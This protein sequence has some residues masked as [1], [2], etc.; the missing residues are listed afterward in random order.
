M[1][2]A[3][4]EY[5]RALAEVSDCAGSP[6][7]LSS[8]VG[9]AVRIDN[10]RAAEELTW[11]RALVRHLPRT[12]AALRVGTIDLYK[13][14][15]VA[16]L[17]TSLSV[18][19]L[20]RAD[21]L[22]EK[23][24]KKTPKNLRRAV[25]GVVKNVDPDGDEERRKKCEAGR[26]VALSHRDHGW[27]VLSADLPCH[28]ASAIY[29]SLTDAAR[30]LRKIDPSRTMDQL[31]ADIFADRLLNAVNGTASV[32]AQVYVYVDLFTLWSLNNDPGYLPGYGEIPADLA[33]QIAADPNSIWTR[34]ITDPDTGQ[35]LSVGR[36]KY[37][38]PA[39]LADYVRIRARTCEHPGCNQPA[40]F[41]DIDHTEDW[42]LGGETNADTLGGRC[43]YHHLLK[44][45]PGWHY[46]ANPD[47]TTT[48]TTPAG[49]T[50][51]SKP[52]PIHKPRS[53]P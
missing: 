8:E 36:T 4:E 9:L 10:D 52:D 15:I 51:T 22:L 46:Q 6:R 31:R 49:R 45:E 34:L 41:V 25:Y 27:S 1:C 19:Q 14:F 20:A 33:R 17:T 44:N 35:L 3:Q 42:A 18:E 7:S 2:A 28:K 29:Q 11:A 50:Y 30:E 43:R 40:E 38:P 32:K 47:G 48:I 5:V 26:K 23:R 24:L 13:A 12:L 39:A 21:V 53:Q 37:R 16:E